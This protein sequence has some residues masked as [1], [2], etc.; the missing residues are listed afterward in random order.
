M[1]IFRSFSIYVVAS[2]L[3]AAINF[4]LL[5]Y[6]SNRL[7]PADYGMVAIFNTYV[8][9]LAPLMSLLCY[10]YL[11]VQYYKTKDRSALV[12]AVSSVH[13]IPFLF[14]LGYLLVVFLFYRPLTAAMEVPD[15]SVPW[16]LLVPVFG[17]IVNY[18]EIF[19][20]LLII[21]KR[22]ALFGG[23]T[24]ARVLLEA[25][26]TICL[27]SVFDLGWEGR[28]FAWLAATVLLM[29]FGFVHL[30]RRG[31]LKPV[32]DAS[33]VRA[34]LAFGLPL[35]LHT[36]G[37]F[38]I[39]QS[40]RLFLT[41]MISI[42]EMGIY[43]VGY[44]IG[45]IVLIFCTAFNN[46]FVPFLYERLSHL[47][48]KGKKE[49]ARISLF[50][51][52]ALALV[53]AALI[54]LSPWFFRTFLD[55]RYYRGWRYVSWIGLA[56]W[57]WGIYLVFS[58]YLFYYKRTRFLTFLAVFNVVVNIGLNYLLIGRYG[59][60]G[61]AYATA[62]S[63]FLVTVIVVAAASRIHPF[64]FADALRSGNPTGEVTD[65]HRQ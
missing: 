65:G 9:I 56:Y 5:P 14:F 29:L 49:I 4:L 51:I 47:T 26:L 31:L 37:K 6:L 57:F 17:L 23:I 58:G 52:L 28:L 24:V 50:F 8:S 12:R 43:N 10:S 63:F 55:A 20:S 30:L 13:A 40:D 41:K 3:S 62:L 19:N 53:V 25:V 36:I 48:E 59:A 32:W 16:L 2:V 33:F 34:S 27:I 1:K 35:L 18:N 44:Q 60:I 7:T 42:S 54:L 45:S 11:N 15:G 61:A 46:S 39:N 64:R 21:E 38:I 22:A